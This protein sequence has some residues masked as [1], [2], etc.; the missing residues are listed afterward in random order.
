MRTV[1]TST[2]VHPVGHLCKFPCAMDRSR[3][4]ALRGTP[5]AMLKHKGL[6]ARDMRMRHAERKHVG[7]TKSC[8]SE[9]STHIREHPSNDNF[10]A[11][12][13]APRPGAVRRTNN[14]RRA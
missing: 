8:W 3:V 13:G 7:K 9:H 6:G 1:Y 14:Y 4:C 2:R 5:S 11:A 10:A 12:R